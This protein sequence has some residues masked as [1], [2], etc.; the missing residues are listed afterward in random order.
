MLSIPFTLHKL[1]FSLRFVALVFI[2]CNY[3]GFA[4]N[5][6]DTSNSCVCICITYYIGLH[7]LTEPTSTFT[8]SKTFYVLLQYIL[9]FRCLFPLQP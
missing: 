2:R 5:F 4:I 6:R 3:K 9:L 1:F 7:C 8:D